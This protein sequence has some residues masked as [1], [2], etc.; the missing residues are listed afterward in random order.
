M[1]RIIIKEND[2][3]IMYIHNG[4]TKF[5]GCQCFKDCTCNKYFKPS[6]Y[7]YYTVCRKNKKTTTHQT[8]EEANN[9]WDYVC[10]L[11]K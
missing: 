5:K 9:R 2:F 6:E 1:A 11:N 4:T 8:L 10:S 7:N 3:N